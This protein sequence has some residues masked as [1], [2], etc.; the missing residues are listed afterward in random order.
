M[1]AFARVVLFDLDGTLIDS[2]ADL[3][4]A[5]NEMRAAR[6]LPPLPFAQFRPIVTPGPITV[7]APITVPRPIST[8]APMTTFEPMVTSRSKTGAPRSSRTDIMIER[9]LFG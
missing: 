3:A 6:G 4:A 1:S 7:L 9:V 8:P 2:A 5:G